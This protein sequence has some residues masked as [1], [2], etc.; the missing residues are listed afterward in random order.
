MTDGISRDTEPGRWRSALGRAGVLHAPRDLGQAALGGL[1]AFLVVFA[2]A[3]SAERIA[4]L[5]LIAPFGASCVLVFALPDSPLARARN[6]IGGH[7]LSALV[8]VAVFA[9]LGA[10]PFSMALGVG[11][12]TVAMALTGTL[13]PPAGGNPLL[14]AAGAAGWP[15]IAAVAAGAGFIALAGLL[16]RERLSR[17]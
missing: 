12:A 14:A 6:V 8:G 11:L 16:Y 15:F 9:L 4:W 7:V 1:A 17:S 3:I 10:S 2:L 5:L 13:H